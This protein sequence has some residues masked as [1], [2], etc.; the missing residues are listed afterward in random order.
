MPGYQRCA[1]KGKCYP[2]LTARTGGQTPGIV[3]EGLG[4]AELRRLDAYEGAQ[5]RR[6]RVSVIVGQGERL[7]A[8]CYVMHPRQLHRLTGRDWSVET[9]MLKS[10]NSYL[11]RL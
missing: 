4:A 9:F 1:I 6:I 8:W 10:L 7:A 5:Y 3:Y 11:A 2:G